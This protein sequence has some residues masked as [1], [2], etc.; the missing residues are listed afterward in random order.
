MRKNI[1][2]IPI[3]INKAIHEGVPKNPGE[4][5]TTSK[6]KNIVLLITPNKEKNFLHGETSEIARSFLTSLSDHL[7][8]L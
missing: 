5:G 8:S 2:P 7:N 4:P 6:R 1:T 3:Q